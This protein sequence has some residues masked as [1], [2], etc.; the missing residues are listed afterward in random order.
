[1]TYGFH[2]AIDENAD[3]AQR[4][5]PP[6]E[7]ERFEGVAFSSAGN[8]IAVATASGNGVLLYRQKADGRYED[9]PYSRIG[10]P[11]C[12]LRYPHD[13]AFA[14]CG[15]GELLVVAQRG[16]VITIFEINPVNAGYRID[17]V[18]EIS[19]PEA[20]LASTDGAALVPPDNRCL[21]VCNLTS[22]S[23][24]FYHRRS[25]SPIAFE[26]IPF[27]ELT[28]PSLCNPDGLAFSRCGSWLAVTNH[29]NHSVSIFQ[30]RN[31]AS[32]GGELRYGEEPVTVIQ[33]PR[34]RYP[35]SVA[36]TPW[37]NHLVVTNAGA[38]Y[39]NVYPPESNYSG[40]RWSQSPTL[41]KRVGRDG[42]FIRVNAAN[43]M[44]GGAK[45]IAIHKNNLAI[46]SP[47]F[48]VEIYRFDETVLNHRPY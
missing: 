47:E 4:L 44:E 32:A 39:V 17:L 37:T 23:I 27:F 35:H 2:F 15:D 45:G 1:V 38:G 26:P 12:Q 42:T 6:N 14:A 19:G 31:K 18:Q 30:R 34:L 21:A 22:A 28:H 13:V 41:Q 10:E 33:D 3:P 25:G 11:A 16:E 29:G 8:L 43:K 46:C 9:A 36:F 24:N 48:G 5:A 40:T 20:K 7:A